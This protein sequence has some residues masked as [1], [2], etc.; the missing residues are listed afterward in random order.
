MP[1]IAA[2]RWMV[3]QRETWPD[4]RLSTRLGVA[5]ALGISSTHLKNIEDGKSPLK[6]EMLCTYLDVFN[7]EGEERAQ[8]LRLYVKQTYPELYAALRGNGV[9]E[10]DYRQLILDVC[11]SAGFTKQEAEA[12]YAEGLKEYA[13]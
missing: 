8:I 3:S 7:V 11:E 5:K 9:P 10:V 6:P 4:R 12:T 1:S 13:K 2:R